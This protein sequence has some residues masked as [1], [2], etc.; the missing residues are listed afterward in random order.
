[1]SE[2]VENWMG[3]FDR[4]REREARDL[5]LDMLERTRAELIA[6]GKAAAVVLV[7]RNGKV[8]ST[9]VRKYMVER[10]YGDKMAKVDPRWLGTLFRRGWTRVGYETTGSH[11][12]PVSVWTAT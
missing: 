1:M 8:T 4:A 7:A 10:G 11:G 9:D 12:R 3:T 5:A 2:R 6:I